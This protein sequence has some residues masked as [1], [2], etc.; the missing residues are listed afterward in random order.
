MKGN[1]EGICHAHKGQWGTFAQRRNTERQMPAV[2]Q[3]VV[4]VACILHGLAWGA[5]GG[6]PELEEDSVHIVVTGTDSLAGMLACCHLGS[7]LS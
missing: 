4:A 2:G 6:Q 3:V 1:C 5:W 7:S